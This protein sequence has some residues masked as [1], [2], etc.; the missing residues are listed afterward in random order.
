MSIYLPAH[1]RARTVSDKACITLSCGNNQKSG[2][3]VHSISQ[4]LPP[5]KDPID[6]DSHTLRQRCFSARVYVNK[7][8]GAGASRGENAKIIA[9]GE[10]RIERSE[11]VRP[12]IVA[13]RDVRLS[14]ESRFQRNVR[15][16]VTGFRSHCPGAYVCG[17]EGSELPKRFIVEI[18]AGLHLGDGTR[19]TRTDTV[20]HFVAYTPVECSCFSIE[21]KVVSVQCDSLRQ[22]S[23][24]VYAPKSD[25]VVWDVIEKA[26][27]VNVRAHGEAVN[28]PRTDTGLHL[29]PVKAQAHVGAFA[30]IDQSS[31]AILH[32]MSPD[33][34]LDP[35]A[36]IPR[37]DFDE[38]C[39]E[40]EFFFVDRPRTT[41]AVRVQAAFKL[42]ERANVFAIMNVDMKHVPFVEI[43]VHER[44]L[45][46]IVVS[47]LF[48]NLASFAAH[49]KEP[50]I[51]VR[52]QTNVFDGVPKL[53][54]LSRISE[55]TPVIVLAKQVIDPCR[56]WGFNGRN[57]LAS[58]EWQTRKRHEH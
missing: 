3:G 33:S 4:A 15:K 22:R 27:L 5:L 19:K 26:R 9:L 24:A 58:R 23:D 45:A 8:D 46:P 55:K 11:C 37:S 35:V 21:A 20:P 34:E 48:P 17:T 49:G 51:P 14:A 40:I 32:L 29:E 38:C 18:P 30:N 43:G 52:A 7:V 10:Q 28:L 39:L 53:L 54:P 13:A 41:D 47:D 57:R 50:V 44:L 25:S 2:D 36:F 1:F 56:C 42:H 12:R 16:P 6:G 31:G